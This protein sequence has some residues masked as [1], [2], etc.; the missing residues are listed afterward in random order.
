MTKKGSFTLKA[1]VL[2]RPGGPEVLKV[3]E[4]EPPV[5]KPHSV[6]ILV[7]ASGVNRADLVQRRGNYPP[8]FGES[9]LLGLEVAGEVIESASVYFK[10][11]DKVAA[12]LAGGGY[13]EEVV[14]SDQ[15]VL[16]LPTFISYEE[17]AAFIETFLTAYL[18][19]FLLGQVT[20]KDSVL[21]HAGTSGVGLSALQLLQVFGVSKVFVTVGSREKKKF[22]ERFNVE[23]I[24]YKEESLSKKISHVDFILDPVGASFF[25]EH[26]KILNLEGR[27]ILIGLMGG[28]RS[29][30]DLSL[31][32]SKRIRLQGSTL[33]HL[34]FEKKVFYFKKF[35]EE[36]SP[37]VF[38]KKVF[39]ILDKVFSYL[40]VQKA[41][42]RMELNENIGKMILRWG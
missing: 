42:E 1:I 39:P 15:L 38:S 22:L 32:L 19:V 2:E 11:G 37:L 5:L 18:N 21:I 26:L 6:R 24:L 27:L 23:P 20:A 14:V 17:G 13:A 40:D 10:T 33:R 8:P 3:Q 4:I 7:R 12:L 28:S 34:P 35:A 29:A 31:L 9:E 16:S 41:H 30:I 36:I 25:E